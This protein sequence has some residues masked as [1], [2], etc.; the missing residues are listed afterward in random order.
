M[1]ESGKGTMSHFGTHI[2]YINVLKNISVDCDCNGFGAPP[3]CPDIGI[4]ASTD[5]LA[6]DQASID[7]LYAMPEN[8]RRD[9]VQRIE[10]RSGLHQLEYMATLQM[11]NRQYDL[12]DL[13]AQA[14]PAIS[15]G[16]VSD[17]WT[18]QP[19]VAG[20]SWISIFGRNFSTATLTWDGADFSRGLPASLAGVSV[21][22]N[23]KAAP[24]CF[25]SPGQVN[26]L[27]PVDLGLGAT[28][29]TIS[30]PGGTS[31][32]NVT[33]TAT[34]PAFYAPGSS[35][36]SFFVT[37]QSSNGELVGNPRID[38]RVRR[39]L[40]PGEVVSIFGTGFGEAVGAPPTTSMF[41]GAFSLRLQPVITIG[42]V[43]VANVTG[44]LVSP[45]LYQFNITVPN[46]P[47]GDYPIVAS[48]AG[49]SSSRSAVVT[50]QR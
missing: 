10:S 15:E 49:G 27:A 35:G 29:V 34:L 13:A 45:G 36:G 42:G 37:A 17:P 7:L 43:T 1:A 28:Q 26:V 12:I 2:T 30:T 14:A 20:S 25:V 4:V 40:Q 5:I 23:G 6:V 44:Y 31:S 18:Y 16:G 11:G 38:S 22:M 3:T 8:Q 48:L 21:T 32:L 9:M 39:A 33:A 19:G 24:I 41:S 46:L 47:D 50:I